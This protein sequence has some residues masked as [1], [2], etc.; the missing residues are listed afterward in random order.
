MSNFWEVMK[1]LSE[2]QEPGE[3]VPVEQKVEDNEEED[4][5]VRSVDSSLIVEQLQRQAFN[6]ASCGKSLQRIKQVTYHLGTQIRIVCSRCK[7]ELSMLRDGIAFVLDMNQERL[8][9]HFALLV[10]MT[11]EPAQ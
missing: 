9:K 1:V 7:G 4:K 6:C 2:V 5:I 8:P 11:K 10:D 3:Q